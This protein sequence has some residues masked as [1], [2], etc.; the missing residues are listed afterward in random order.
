MTTL[1]LSPATRLAGP[2]DTAR[3]G[4]YQPGSPPLI[5]FHGRITDDGE[6][7]VRPFRYH[8]YGARSCAWSHQV[9]II[10]ELAGL[11]DIVTMSYVDEERDGRGWAFRS[12]YGP[13]PVNG[14]TFLRQA[15]EATEEGFDGHVSVPALWDRFSCRI[16]SNDARTIGIDLAT[17]FRHLADPVIDTYPEPLRERIEDLDARIAPVIG[18]GAG[19]GELLETFE[20]LDA[21]LDRSRYLL[22]DTLTQADIRLWVRLVRY[23]VGPNAHRRINPGLHVFPHLWRYAREL[24]AIPAFR[25]TTDFSAIAAPGVTVPDWG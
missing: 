3:H 17:R 12:R 25:T 15:Y 22:G 21:R 11:P 9:A 4:E 24:Y 19:R 2:A 16:A 5:R 23:D 20:M 7:T 14:F 10:R 13:D 1:R 8:L 6:F 18:G